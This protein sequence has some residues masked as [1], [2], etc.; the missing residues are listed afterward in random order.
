MTVSQLDRELRRFVEDAKWAE[1]NGGGASALGLEAVKHHD[2]LRVAES[3]QHAQ[4]VADSWDRAR[5]TYP[6]RVVMLDV[7]PIGG[8]RILGPILEAM[9]GWRPRPAWLRIPLGRRRPR[10]TVIVR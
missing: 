5:E 9:T 1:I 8:G 7:T 4:A 10:R 6:R 3:L 2:A